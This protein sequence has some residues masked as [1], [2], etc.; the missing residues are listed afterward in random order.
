MDFTFGI[1]TA[2]GNVG[3]IN[4]IINSIEKELIPNYEIII[5]G[6]EPIERNNTIR[7]PF[8]E[9]TKKGWITRKKNLIT[10]SASYDNIVYL[11]DYIK[12]NEGWY[13]GQ[14]LAGNDFKIRMDKIINYDGTRFRDWC[15]WP[16]NDNFM[17]TL[18]QRNCLIP[19]EMKHL[20]KYQYI[21]GS[22]WV[23]KKEVMRMFPLDET[24]SWGE[25]EDVL[26]SKQVREKYDF[27]MN[28]NSSVQIMKQGKDKVFSETTDA[29]NKQLITV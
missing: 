22:Y 5:V 9:S 13:K 26:W 7:I 25:S 14:L 19:Y 21:S 28:I 24:L 8:T 27:D 10:D 2:G 4:E 18:I 20:S 6:G 16:H 15:I 11:H 17:D 23:G 3:F 29:Q 12:L 1:I